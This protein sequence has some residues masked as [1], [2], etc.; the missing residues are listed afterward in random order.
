MPAFKTLFLLLQR[1]YP[2]FHAAEGVDQDLMLAA[3]VSRPEVSFACFAPFLNDANTRGFLAV[4]VGFG[5]EQLE[6]LST[7]LDLTL[8]DRFKAMPYYV[9]K[10]FHSSFLTMDLTSSSPDVRQKTE[11]DLSSVASYLNRQFGGSLRS[12]PPF[13]LHKLG[14][15]VGTRVEWQK[16]R[17]AKSV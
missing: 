5:Y 4:E 13:H 12:L 9:E 17:P 15:R 16:L 14:T 3:L 11:A 1:E 2:N 8:R 10:R 6:S 7:T